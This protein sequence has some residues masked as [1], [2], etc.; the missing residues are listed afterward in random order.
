MN[1]DANAAPPGGLVVSENG[2]EVFRLPPKNDH[3]AAADQAVGINRAS[4]V[5]PEGVMELS[6]TVAEND[7][8]QRVEPDYPEAAREQN[9]QGTVVLEVHIAADGGVQDVQVISGPPVLAEASTDAVK[10]WKFKPRMV[11]GSP[12]EMETRI[13]LKFRLPQPKTSQ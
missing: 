6:P 10:Q 12:V 13:T 11:K 4:S 1:P 3:Q 8:L 2:K 7:L 9:I 5:E